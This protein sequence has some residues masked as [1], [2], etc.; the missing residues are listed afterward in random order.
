MES[1]SNMPRPI[2]CLDVET[3]GLYGP[4][5]AVGAVVLDERGRLAESLLSVRDCVMTDPFAARVVMP[6]LAQLPA[7]ASS[8]HELCRGFWTWY[9]RVR[10]AYEGLLFFVDCGYP[11]ETNFLAKCVEC[12]PSRAK[13]SP[14]PV[15]ELATLLELVE[16]D[17]DLGR[18][19]YVADQITE[20][21]APHDPSFDAYVSALCAQKA[22]AALER[23]GAR[24]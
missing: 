24:V 18:V 14:Y 19:P 1:V 16:G 8:V 5:V 12:D 20:P 15:H 3:D 23:G 13:Q 11:V 4:P 2:L 9:A 10:E 7:T 21:F 17:A 22:L 6:M